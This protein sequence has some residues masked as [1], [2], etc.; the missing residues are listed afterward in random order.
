LI[1][2]LD[3]LA[4]ACL[5]LWPLGAALTHW[6]GLWGG[7]ATT[8]LA[9]GILCLLLARDELAPLLRPTARLMA[10]GVI[11]GLVMLLATYATYPLLSRSWTLLGA[12]VPPLYA[13]F[14]SPR[15]AWLV[16]A[17]PLVVVAEELAWRGVVFEA[18]RRRLPT[19]PAVIA[20]AVLYAA[21][22]A[23]AASLVLTG[24]ALACGAFWSALRARTR[25]LVPCTVAHLIWDLMVMVL[26]PL[27]GR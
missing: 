4:L 15:P 16:L 20:G 12:G 2:R 11:A 19:L 17:L 1:A 22:H 6:V 10:L 27:D 24:V 21:A 23:P 9:L 14:R 25:S 26:K 3:R 18:L 8:A 13:A 5:V 7:I